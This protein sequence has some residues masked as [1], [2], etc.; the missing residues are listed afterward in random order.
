M[1]MASLVIL[2]PAAV[3]LFG[4]AAAVV[5]KA[6]LAGL[7]NAGPHGFT[8]VLYAFSSAGNNNGS[9]FAGLHAD[10]NFYNLTLGTAMLIGRYGVIVPVLA[11]AGSLARKKTIPAGPGTLPTHTILFAILLVGIIL[12]IGALTF[13][14]VLSLGPLAEFMMTPK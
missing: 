3:V 4:T 9:A 5:T 12:I 8:E 6:G 2:L 7:Q 1:Q 14:P 10:S 13:L 11:I